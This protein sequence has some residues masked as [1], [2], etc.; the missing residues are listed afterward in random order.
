MRFVECVAGLAPSEL[1]TW[2]L[3][4]GMLYY[5]ILWILFKVIRQKSISDPKM[6]TSSSLHC[7]RFVVFKTTLGE[8]HINLSLTSCGA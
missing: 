8:N 1:E 6:L 4:L 7:V 3:G 2:A 5:V